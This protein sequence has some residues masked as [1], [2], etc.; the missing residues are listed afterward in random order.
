MTPLLSIIIPTKG[1]Y[2][3]L[4][5][6]LDLILS[7][8]SKEFE[9]IIQDNT[10]DN[11]VFIPF[12][13]TINDPR[14]KY[15]YES[16]H[17]TSVENFD[18]AVLN[19]S[20]KY[21]AFIGDDDFLLRNICDIVSFMNNNDID[22]VKF[23]R[24]NYY[25]SDDFRKN[26]LL[27]TG[28]YSKKIKYLS[29]IESLKKVLSNGCQ[30]IDLLPSLYYGI[31]KKESLDKI[32]AIG[33]TYFPGNSADIANG[34]AL[35]FFIKKYAFI[36]LPIIVP[37][38]SRNTGGG[39]YAKKNKTLSLDEVSFISK[40]AIEK[41]D[42]SLPRIWNGSLVWPESALSALKYVDRR[43]FIQYLNYKNI[44]LAYSDISH[45]FFLDAKKRYRNS[46]SFYIAKSR[47]F[48]VRVIRSALNRIIR[49]IVKK[50]KLDGHY[51]ANI[52]SIVEA[53]EFLYNEI[54]C[55]CCRFL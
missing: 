55:Y 6:I 35:S 21:I 53:E 34:V 47:V 10:S 22:A 19:T 16:S 42:S 44:W 37:G 23:R 9:L 14:F 1:R 2:N 17:L 5:E 41:W 25:W 51:Y 20:G 12:L 28:L 15:Y 45:E 11:A 3:Y 26:S 4:K 32:Y 30:E 50:Y 52:G 29:P 48:M 13:N 31:V 38:T 24:A 7:F 8:D 40:K 43:D 27:T 46:L 18:K 54:K 49:I 39:V 33:N 36:N